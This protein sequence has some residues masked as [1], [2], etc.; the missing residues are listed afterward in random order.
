M[1]GSLRRIVDLQWQSIPERFPDVVLDEYVIMPNH[2]HGIFI[3]GRDTPCGYP[4]FVNH[5]PGH[6]QGAPRR[7]PTVGDIVGSFKS[8]C[9]NNW[10]KTIKA[11]KFDAIGTFWQSNYYEHVVRDDGEMERIRRYIAENPLKWELDWEN[12]ANN[13]QQQDEQW[14]V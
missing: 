9:V 12:P 10:L 14:M 7:K 5:Q 2:L 4:E 11:E 1:F 6:P 3:I 8:L 13:K